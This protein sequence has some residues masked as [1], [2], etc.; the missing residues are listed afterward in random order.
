MDSMILI[1]TLGDP[2]HEFKE[3]SFKMT[4]VFWGIVAVVICIIEKK[5]LDPHDIAVLLPLLPVEV[6]AT[7]DYT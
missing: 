3:S 7:D 5:V 4:N 6:V 1:L 2:S